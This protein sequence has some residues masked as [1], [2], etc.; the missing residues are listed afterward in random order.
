MAD[1]RTLTPV[2]RWPVSTNVGDGMARRLHKTAEETRQLVEAVRDLGQALIGSL[3]VEPHTYRDHTPKGGGML[4]EIDAQAA[5]IERQLAAC[6]DLIRNI[7][8]QL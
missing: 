4:A 2:A 1:E 7:K 8:R 3:P 5:E 6:R